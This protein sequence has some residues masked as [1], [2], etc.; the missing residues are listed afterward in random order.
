MKN[1]HAQNARG[2]TEILHIARSAGPRW[3]LG[4]LNPQEINFL[5]KFALRGIF[6]KIMIFPENLK[7]HHH[8][9]KFECAQTLHQKFFRSSRA[10]NLNPHVK[11]V[12]LGKRKLKT[13]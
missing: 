10:Q 6:A 4:V 8:V 5:C 1:N 12:M 2:E 3:I 7:F 13:I 11:T 9:S